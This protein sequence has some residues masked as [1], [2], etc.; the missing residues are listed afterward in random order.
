[1]RAIFYAGLALIVTMSSAIAQEEYITVKP[2]DILME[3]EAKIS[4]MCENPN[5][6]IKMEVLKSGAMLILRCDGGSPNSGLPSGAQKLR[7]LSAFAFT[8]TSD[9]ASG[10]PC[11]SWSSGGSSNYYC[12]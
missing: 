5:A 11:I 9:S 3:S 10:D 1:M 6:V 4:A 12:W 8:K 7:L 2:F